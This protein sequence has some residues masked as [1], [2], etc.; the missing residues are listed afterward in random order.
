MLKQGIIE[1]SDSPWSSPVCLVTKKDGSWRF[2]VYFRKLNSVTQKDAYPLP[3]IDDTLETLAGARWFST[4]DLASGY[5]QIKM[6]G[7]DKAKTAFSS[8]LGLYHFNVMPFG[9]SNAPATFERL[10]DNVL[11]ALKWKKCLCYLD[12]VIVFGENF[13][14]ALENLRLVFT[15]FRQA[16]LTLKPKKC[17]LFQ[18]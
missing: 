4:L 3:R 6:R 9:L 11:G 8:H 2:C 12:D 1:P 17:F 10:M 7:K 15:Q 18:T 16:N 13:E 5:W 14:N